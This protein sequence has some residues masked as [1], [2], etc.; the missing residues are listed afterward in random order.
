MVSRDEASDRYT[1]LGMMDGQELYISNPGLGV[2]ETY[3]F[4]GDSA[5]SLDVVR[6]AQLSCGEAS[7]ER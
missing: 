7:P 2:L 6:A 3:G 1:I 5:R 4:L